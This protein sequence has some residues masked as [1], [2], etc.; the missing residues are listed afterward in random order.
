MHGN[1]ADVAGYKTKIPL[2][3]WMKDDDVYHTSL[4]HRAGPA[5]RVLQ[6]DIEIRPTIPGEMSESNE[7][8]LRV[9]QAVV[10]S[11]NVH[12]DGSTFSSLLTLRPSAFILYCMKEEIKPPGFDP[13]SE[14]Y[15]HAA[16]LPYSLNFRGTPAIEKEAESI[17]SSLQ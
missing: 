3:W 5:G 2:F 14:L 4:L 11:R 6:Q 15:C 16:G 1:Y 7:E 12:S 17:L 9:T 10:S 8:A 13:E